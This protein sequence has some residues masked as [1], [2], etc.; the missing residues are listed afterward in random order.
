MMKT[1]KEGRIGGRCRRCG[2]RKCRNTNG[3]GLKDMVPGRV[4]LGKGK[5]V[6]ILITDQFKL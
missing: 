6:S 2:P 5:S 1:V 4:L 3:I